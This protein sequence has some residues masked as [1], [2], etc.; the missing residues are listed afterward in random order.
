[1]QEVIA[2]RAVNFY[3]RTWDPIGTRDAKAETISAFTGISLDVLEGEDPTLES[4]AQRMSWASKRKTTRPEDMA[5]C[6]L[7]IFDINMPLLYGEGAEKAFI[8]LQ[9]EIMKNSD[10]Q[11]LFAWKHDEQGPLADKPADGPLTGLLAGSPLC[12]ENC[13]AI[14]PRR[15]LIR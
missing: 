7:S 4:I 10:D 1:L 12:F 5:Y 6:L 2:P 14:V 9:E 13:G 15:R 3:S 8:R 11:S